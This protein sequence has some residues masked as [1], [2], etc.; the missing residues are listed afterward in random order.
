MNTKTGFRA[1]KTRSG[2]ILLILLVFVF[3]TYNI[4][5]L[6]AFGSLLIIVL[7][8]AAWPDRN[9]EQLGLRIPPSQA[10]IA[11]LLCLLATLC[12]WLLISFV[13][14]AQ[15]I[16]L[17]PLWHRSTWV[18]L[19]VHTL[20]QSL[21]EEMVLGSLLLKYAAGKLPKLPPAAISILVALAFSLLHYAF[22]G[23]RPVTMINY[24]ALLRANLMQARQVHQH[25]DAYPVSKLAAQHS[26]KP[27]AL[28]PAGKFTQ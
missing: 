6:A 11:L 15:A 9:I 20:G 7:S 4:W 17:T 24:G 27:G 1:G 10:G 5:W 16:Q 19:I 14:P 25:A 12:A 26:R 21:N 2:I 22:Y 8:F 3:F 18:F 13:A 28:F 23:L